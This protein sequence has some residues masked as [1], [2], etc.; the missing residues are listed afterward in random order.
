MIQHLP[1]LPRLTM[2]DIEALEANYPSRC[3]RPNERVEDH[4]RYA[5][6]V[7]LIAVLKSFV[8]PGLEFTPD[9]EAAMDLM[10]EEIANKQQGVE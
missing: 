7:E 6:K 1:Q 4:L 9:E 10:A 2:R 3:L 8:D 5:G